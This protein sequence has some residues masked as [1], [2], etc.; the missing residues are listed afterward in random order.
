MY[1]SRAKNPKIKT[2]VNKMSTKYLIFKRN[3]SNFE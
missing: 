1:K 2:I 3:K